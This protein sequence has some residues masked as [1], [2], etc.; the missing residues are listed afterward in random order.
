MSFYDLDD[1]ST[2]PRAEQ[3]V[4]KDKD[5]SKQQEQ[6]SAHAPGPVGD[7]ELLARSLE[8]PSK[9]FIAQGGLNDSLFQDAF[10]HGASA[11]RLPNGWEK[12]DVDIHTRF[13]TRAKARRQGENGK[14]A[15]PE[16]T[17]IGAFHMTAGEL[18]SFRLDGD[19]TAR[20]RVYDAGNDP[21]DSLHAEVIAD[22]TGLQRQQR[23][24]LRV[25]LMNLAN[26]RGLYVSPFLD[27]EGQKRAESSQC[28]L[29][30]PSENL[31]RHLKQ[32][33]TQHADSETSPAI[34]PT[35]GQVA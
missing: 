27:S 32:E 6:V 22:A 31:L 11:Q 35:D 18:R 17:Y 25:R 15:N 19:D 28:Q 16:F 13:E 5:G 23:K 7:A 4:N 3:L 9:F 14:P 33:A 24:V 34:P 29:N 10:S 21:T 26:Q 1:T 2:L 12:H 30:A 20:V 8:Y